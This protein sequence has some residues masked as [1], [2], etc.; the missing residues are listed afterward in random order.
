MVC[1]NGE[2]GGECWANENNYPVIYPTSTE[3]M[4]RTSQ[5]QHF[6]F[7][8]IL[9]Q[10]G[11]SPQVIFFQVFYTTQDMLTLRNCIFT[12][13]ISIRSAM[14]N[15]DYGSLIIESCRFRNITSLNNALIEYSWAVPDGYNIVRNCTFRGISNT[16]ISTINPAVWVS[17]VEIQYQRFFFFFVN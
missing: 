8:N 12:A 3:L 16:N 2:G 9:F 17:T 13:N 4:F 6:T 1:E 7:A 14:I 11:T 15:N 10:T 5:Q